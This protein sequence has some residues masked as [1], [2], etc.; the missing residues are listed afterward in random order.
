MSLKKKRVW[1]LL[2]TCARRFASRWPRAAHA[3]TSA[4]AA[5]ME[6]AA[7]AL[8]ATAR[9]SAPRFFMYEG[10]DYDPSPEVLSRIR[11]TLDRESDA[12]GKVA[13]LQPSPSHPSCSR[14]PYRHSAAF[15]TSAPP[16]RCSPLCCITAALLMP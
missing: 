14:C 11:S 7:S 15:L 16:P 12:N 4:T 13:A 3:A 9:P 2:L 5:R 1:N 6:R 8:Q 10:P